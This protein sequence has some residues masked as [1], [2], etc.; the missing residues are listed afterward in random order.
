MRPVRLKLRPDSAEYV[1][2]MSDL[3]N[4][5]RREGEAWAR[6]RFEQL[7]E[8]ERPVPHVWPGLIAVAYMVAEDL[9]DNRVIQPRDVRKLAERI[10]E[11]A[12]M[13]WSTLA[14]RPA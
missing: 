4:L 6:R 5:A 1:V 13:T 3:E 10:N 7:H 8:L 9:A 12:A 11:C 2:V 14:R